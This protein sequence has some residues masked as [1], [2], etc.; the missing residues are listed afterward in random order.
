M[1]YNLIIVKI[2]NTK[3]LNN[4]EVITITS[5]IKT[6]ANNYITIALEEGTPETLAEMTMTEKAFAFVE[7]VFYGLCVKLNT[8]WEKVFEMANFEELM[9][10]GLNCT[11]EQ[12]DNEVFNNW[13][14]TRLKQLWNCK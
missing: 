13:V 2:R 9:A 14:L 5:V 4:K 11:V 1:Q 8:E 3:N 7:E 6:W 10:E 12:L